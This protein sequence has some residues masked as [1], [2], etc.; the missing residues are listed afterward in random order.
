MTRIKSIDGLRGVAVLLVLGF[1]LGLLKGGWIGVDIFFVISGYVI[2]RMLLHEHA[3]TGGIALFKFWSNRMLRL[4]PAAFVMIMVV[5]TIQLFVKFKTE[6]TWDALGALTNVSNW[7]QL[8]FGHG[9]WKQPGQVFPLEHTWSLA[10]EEQFYLVWPLIMVGVARL[11]RRHAFVLMATAT[12]LAGCWSLWLFHVT[13]DMSRIYMGTDTRAVA[14]LGG[15]T[16]ACIPLNFL[17]H[18]KR[19]G[20]FAP[21][22]AFAG[23]S[24][25]VGAVRRSGNEPDVYRG[26][27]LSLTVASVLLV[28]ALAT[29]TKWIT[30]LLSV[31]PLLYVGARSYSLY[32]WHWPIICLTGT[33]LVTL[34]LALL[35]TW[36]ATELSYNYIEMPFRKHRLA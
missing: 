31:K 5:T 18:M 36:I 30:S 28:L 24:L 4:L 13:Q 23:F 19:Y 25:A 32:L 34:P 8:K 27:L 17:E 1:H 6:A 7:T 21:S 9:Y 10:I 2:T 35:A 12:V 14:L 29:E 33:S 22:A 16:V 3:E 11:V 26:V 15:A 20:G